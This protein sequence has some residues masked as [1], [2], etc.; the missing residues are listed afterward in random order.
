MRDPKTENFL[1]SGNYKWKYHEKIKFDEIDIKASLENPA[2]LYQ[3]VD[4]E[5]ALSYALAMEAGDQ[6]PAIVL[7]TIDST[8]TSILPY[9]IAT[10]V[11]RVHGAI[12][13]KVRDWF[14]AYV[15]AEADGLRR[16]S[17]IRRLNILEGYGVSITDRVA[18]ALQMNR[19]FPELSLASLAK[20]WHV[21]A[22]TLKA[23]KSFQA[24]VKRGLQFGHALDDGRMK[25][26]SINALGQ[27][28]S[29][30]VFDKAAHFATLNSASTS[31]IVD[32]CQDIK[33]TR[34]EA[35]ALAIIEHATVKAAE[36]RMANKAI[37][38]K[39]PAAPASK[40]F[41]M[42]RGLINQAEKG[43]ERLHLAAYDNKVGH[44]LCEQVEQLLQRV[45]AELDRIKRI[46]KPGPS[47]H[48]QGPLH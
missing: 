27:I 8:A 10:G 5:R 38:A 45:K 19:D 14:D 34:D 46:E 33:K 12:E 9:L 36:K 40:F 3:T 16:I 39:V 22:D 35:S 26:K 13:H 29:N 31:D 32:M 23:A 15:V 25:Q 7:L 1:N 4:E 37:H 6:F 24:T 21:K 41:G 11:H 17:L 43:L 48:H 42:M 44:S 18:Q 30:V 28:H 47:P 2:R 20:D